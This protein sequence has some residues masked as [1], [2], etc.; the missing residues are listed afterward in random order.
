[1]LKMHSH[2]VILKITYENVEKWKSVKFFCE[3]HSGEIMNQDMTNFVHYWQFSGLGYRF[4]QILSYKLNGIRV[5]HLSYKIS[6]F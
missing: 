3:P 4:Q 1:M 5:A 2:E 6:L